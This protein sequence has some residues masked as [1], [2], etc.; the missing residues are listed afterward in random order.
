MHE[1]GDTCED[2]SDSFNRLRFTGWNEQC[3]PNEVKGSFLGIPT[4]TKKCPSGYTSGWPWRCKKQDVGSKIGPKAR[5]AC[6][7]PDEELIG[8][9]CY[10]TCREGY[11]ADGKQCVPDTGPG[12]R[13]AVSER[14]YCPEGLQRI[15]QFC[16]AP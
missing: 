6:P 11:A 1:K 3:Y 9:E 10:E 7:N 16:Y 8:T 4:C 14:Y 12:V 13:T 5:W 15:G 2:L